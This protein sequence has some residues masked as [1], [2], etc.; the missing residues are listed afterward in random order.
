M[1]SRADA[2]QSGVRRSHQDRLRALHA[3]LERGWIT[4]DELLQLAS[5]SPVDIDE[6]VTLAREAGIDVV[7][8]QGDAWSDLRILANEG[9]DAFRPVREGPATSDEIAV[10][11]PGTMYL[12]EISHAPLLTAPEEVQLAQELE[13]GRIARERLGGGDFSADE[14]AGLAESVRIGAAARQR[15]IES[16]LRLVV[17]VARKYLGRG[18]SFL[19]LVQEGNIGLQKGVDKYDWRRGFR[20][21]T[22]GYWWIRQAISRA[23]AEHGRTIRLPSHVIERLGRLYNTA[24]ELQEEL[25]RTPRTQEIADRMDVA[26]EQVREAFRAARIPISLEKPIGEDATATLATL[27]V[28][29]GAQRPD[30]EAEERVL[31]ANLDSALRRQL[32]PREAAV[33]RLRFGLDRGG[34]ERTLGDV[35]KELG[36]SRERVRQLETEAMAKLRRAGSFRDEFGEYAE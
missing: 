26:P 24:R 7:E 10:D 32:S 25:G 22:Y 31:A 11:D 1:D 19:D 21:S 3:L 23:V 33:M 15:L 18:V 20:F 2:R 6:A 16:N 36:I 9:P 27:I 5:D 30:E 14:L 13:A 29:S 8:R 35:G 28:D 4:L 34:P 17:S 12:R